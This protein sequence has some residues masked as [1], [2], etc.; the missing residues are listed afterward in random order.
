MPC[1]VGGYVCRAFYDFT[2]PAESNALC[3]PGKADSVPSSWLYSNTCTAPM[4]NP[5]SERPQVRGRT[6]HTPQCAHETTP[7][8]RLV[9]LGT[10]PR[11]PS[12]NEPDRAR[13]ELRRSG[14]RAPLVGDGSTRGGTD[15]VVLS[16]ARPSSSR[17]S[18][19][20]RTRRASCP[21]RRYLQWTKR[22]GFR[23]HSSERN[24]G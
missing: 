16:D 22:W 7:S 5:H 4:R 11:R 17:F 20:R 12:S 6:A 3:L 8:R 10:S 15:E 13:S 18:R 14:S 1:C 21:P 9:D 23:A 2:V 24:R 19:L